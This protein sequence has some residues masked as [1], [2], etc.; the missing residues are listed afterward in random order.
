MKK[1]LSIGFVLMLTIGLTA[2]GETQ[3]EKNEK[4]VDKIIEMA[5]E[6]GENVDDKTKE[7]MKDAFANSN[8]LVNQVEEE[9][10]KLKEELPSTLKIMKFYR[11]CLEDADDKDDAIECYEE[12][13]EYADEL[14]IIEEDDEELDPEEEFGDWTAQDK[15]RLLAEM[16]EGLKMMEQFT[17]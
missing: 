15:E 3:E 10:N 14:G 13:D 8:E 9:M 17:K 11:D 12:A 5:E 4:T 7:M 1:L 6:T 16:D 2:C